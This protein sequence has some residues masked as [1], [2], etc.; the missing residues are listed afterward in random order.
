M[1]APACAPGAARPAERLDPALLKMSFVLVLGPIL[2]LLDTTIVTVGLDAVARDFH[3]PLSTLQ[4]VS[5]GYLLSISMVMPLAGWASDRFGARAM[6][7]TS[8]ALFVAGSALCGLA[9]SAGSLILFRV[10]QG[11]G[12]GL[13]QPIGQSIV[14]R[15]AGPARL[16]RIFGI[17]VLPLTFAPVLGPV[18]GG[19]IVERFDWRWMFLVNVP[20]G[21]VTLLLA[22]RYIPSDG[23]RKAEG[24]RLD[25]LGLALLSP[26]LAAVV[27]GFSEVGDAGGF[28]SS[29][30][31]LAL[32]AGT[33]L[34]PAYG[35]H[36]LRRRD[37]ALIDLRLFARRGFAVATA[38]SFL[39]GAALYSSMLL[40]P[41][42]YQQVEHASALEAGLLLAPQALGTAVATFFAG[43][44]ADR[45][46]ARPLILTGIVLTLAGTVAFTQL[47]SDPAGWLL[48]LSLVVRGA[49]LGVVMAPGMATVYAS[50]QPHETARAAGAV[51]TLNRVGG[52]LGTAILVVVLQRSL[53]HHADAAAAY[54]ETFWWAV[55]LSAL[56]LVPALFYPSRKE[57]S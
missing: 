54:G 41:L 50:V 9:W 22:A 7:M 31:V 12:G 35:A 43:R 6:W 21:L 10:L 45:M 49:G 25:V 52:S 39:Q 44:L 24:N 34:L 48:V 51:N 27:Y 8:V 53:G 37:R 32:T 56:T 15:A 28:G 18:A 57:H 16:G 33:V 40:L 1:T 26:G 23:E 2:A 14:V 29:H 20:L 47:G 30:V 13:I 4:W 19:L 17:T 42:Y 55:G 46:A 11:I 38:N 36:A 5:A 3:S